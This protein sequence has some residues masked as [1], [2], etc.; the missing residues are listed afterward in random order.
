MNMVFCLVGAGSCDVFTPE[1]AG[2]DWQLSI[3]DVMNVVYC[4]VGLGACSAPG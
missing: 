4:L 2:S 3:S 1:G